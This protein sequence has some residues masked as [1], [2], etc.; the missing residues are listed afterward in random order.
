MHC[1]FYCSMF[2]LMSEKRQLGQQLLLRRPRGTGHSNFVLKFARHYVLHDFYNT[3]EKNYFL[4]YL[5]Y[6]IICNRWVFGKTLLREKD[7][8]QCYAQGY[9][10][11]K[12]GFDFI[13]KSSAHGHC[14]NIRE[15]CY[16]DSVLSKYE[17]YSFEQR[18]FIR[19]K[20]KWIGNWVNL[21]YIRREGVNGI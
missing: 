1:Y 11:K 16:N 17:V 19:E 21:Y 18:P 10:Q 12:N 7:L 8:R 4:A 14:R 2:I 3:H 13:W 20:R 15:K 5:R 9:I 6:H